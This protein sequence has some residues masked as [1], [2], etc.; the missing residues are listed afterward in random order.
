MYIGQALVHL[1]GAVIHAF[2]LMPLDVTG[3]TRDVS[4]FIPAIDGAILTLQ[5]G[6]R[7]CG[8]VKENS[9]AEQGDREDKRS[10]HGRTFREGRIVRVLLYERIASRLTSENVDVDAVNAGRP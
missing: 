10:D 2:V 9:A 7:A 4:A 6:H 5:R 8:R 1:P 3:P